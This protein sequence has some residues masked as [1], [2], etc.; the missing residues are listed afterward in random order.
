MHRDRSARSRLI[1]GLILLVFGAF[2]LAVNLGFRIPREFWDYW[3]SIPLLLGIVQVLLPSSTR[4]RLSGIW[5]IAVGIYGFVFV[6]EL[7]GLRWG[8][9]WPIFIIA[10]GIRIVLGG[11]FREDL[12]PDQGGTPS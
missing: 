6:F 1:W 3:P 7:F 11:V 5:L 4:S 10:L 9:A 2:A 8:T 12:K